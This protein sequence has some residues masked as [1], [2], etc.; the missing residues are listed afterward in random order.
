M[1][2]KIRMII[3]ETIASKKGSFSIEEIRKEMEKEEK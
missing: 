1:E 2:R 3:K